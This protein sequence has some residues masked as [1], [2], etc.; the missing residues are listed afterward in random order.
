MLNDFET[1]IL[2]LY[3]SKD[4]IYIKEYIYISSSGLKYI[5]SA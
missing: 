3:L 4:L 1:T 5:G 2:Q